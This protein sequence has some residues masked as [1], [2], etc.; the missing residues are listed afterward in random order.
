MCTAGS[1]GT[2][3]YTAGR[4]IIV[5]VDITTGGAALVQNIPQ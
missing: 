4:W 1:H 5:V 2:H 3:M